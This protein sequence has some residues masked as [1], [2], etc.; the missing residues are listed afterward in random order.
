MQHAAERRNQF[1]VL[2]PAETVG[3]L[4]E[5]RKRLA[6]LSASPV[7]VAPAQMVAANSRLDQ[8]L[9]EQP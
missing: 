6:Q 5:L 1:P 8:P 4:F 7:D 3:I 2:D 9:I